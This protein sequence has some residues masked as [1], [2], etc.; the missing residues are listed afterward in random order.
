MNLIWFLLVSASDGEELAK[1][2][3]VKLVRNEK[4]EGKPIKK[5]VKKVMI[6]ESASKD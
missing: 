3:K 5:K 4:R 6:N 2:Q 1:I